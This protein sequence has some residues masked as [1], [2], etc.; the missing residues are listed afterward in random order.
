M[1][2]F[3]RRLM[4]KK[5]ESELPNKYQKVD[6]IENPIGAYI[7]LDIKATR[8]TNAF[9]KYKPL[10]VQLY[11]C[12]L[13]AGG[14]SGFLFPSV[15]TNFV[16]I[17][18]LNAGAGAV[19]S[20]VAADDKGFYEIKAFWDDKI[21]INGQRYSLKKGNETES[22]YNMRLFKW[23]ADGQHKTSAQTCFVKIYEEDEL[24]RDLIPCY[25]KSDGEVGLFDS[26]TRAFFTNNG[27]GSLTYGYL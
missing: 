25:R 7:D 27:T 12:F 8:N 20:N 13:G 9:Y 3:R 10:A 23:T 21:N 16:Q 6:Y 15:R 11:A 19:L 1:S 5:S 4:Y 2:D 14:G 17:V 24:I 22:L 18:A 26:I